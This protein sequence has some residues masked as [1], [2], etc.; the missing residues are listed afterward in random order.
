MILEAVKICIAKAVEMSGK[1]AYFIPPFN[2]QIKYC[3][4]QSKFQF[5]V[6]ESSAGT[7]GVKCDLNRQAPGYMLLCV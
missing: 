5:Q 6:N 3:N 1:R 7:K 4:P 2:I